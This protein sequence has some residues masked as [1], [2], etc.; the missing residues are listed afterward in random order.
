MCASPPCGFLFMF[1][2]TPAEISSFWSKVEIRGPRECWLWKRAIGSAGYGNLTVRQKYFHSHQVA[3]SISIGPIPDGLWVLHECDNR[4]CCNPGHLFFGTHQDNMDDAAAKG[5]FSSGPA[6]G[7]AVAARCGRGDTS[8][9]R[10]CPESYGI[11][12][13][14]P[15]ARLREI[16]VLQIRS[17]HSLGVKGCWLAEMF[18]ISCALVSLIVNRKLWANL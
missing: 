4:R 12:E 11:G 13:D 15:M 2:F 3:A 18:V 6:H 10:R 8:S 9:R 16:H 5:R 14:H 7:A 17:L 1:T